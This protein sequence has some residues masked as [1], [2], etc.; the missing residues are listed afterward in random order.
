[1]WHNA[2][3]NEFIERFNKFNNVKARVTI[4]HALYGTQKANGILIHT[5][6]DG[7]R[8][9]IVVDGEEKY[10]YMDELCAAYIKERECCIMSDVMKICLKL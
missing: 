8:V 9:G 2:I 6:L 10:I 5:L 1:M 7:E 3:T 4:Q